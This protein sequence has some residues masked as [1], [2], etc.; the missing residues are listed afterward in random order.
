MNEVQKAFDEA[1]VR[2][3]RTRNSAMCARLTPSGAKTARA[4]SGETFATRKVRDASTS[5]TRSACGSSG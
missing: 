5:A 1:L 3:A 2:V 4:S